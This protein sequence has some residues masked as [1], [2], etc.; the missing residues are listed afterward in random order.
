MAQEAREEVRAGFE[1]D[2]KTARTNVPGAPHLLDLLRRFNFLR[3]A[4]KDA[5]ARIVAFAT[6][7]ASLLGRGSPEF[8]LGADL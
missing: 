4:D 3:L 8:H 7:F 1:A 2:V 6:W 5:N